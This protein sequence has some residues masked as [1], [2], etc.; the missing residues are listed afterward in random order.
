MIL[1]IR[2]KTIETTTAEGSKNT[3][4]QKKNKPKLYS[5]KLFS[6]LNFRKRFFMQ[7]NLAHKVIEL[8]LYTYL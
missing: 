1:D 2:K 5:E 7:L 4:K 3:A 6:F 8:A